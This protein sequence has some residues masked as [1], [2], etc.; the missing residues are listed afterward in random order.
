MEKRNFLQICPHRIP[1]ADIYYI[2]L[3]YDHI[4]DNF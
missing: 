2:Y 3:T 1:L 4:S